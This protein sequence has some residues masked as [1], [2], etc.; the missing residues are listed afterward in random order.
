MEEYAQQKTDWVSVDE[1]LP[2]DDFE[3]FCLYK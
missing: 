1:R 2:E 3:M